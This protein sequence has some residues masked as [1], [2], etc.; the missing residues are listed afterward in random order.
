M[1]M[2]YQSY[3]WYLIYNEYKVDFSIIKQ[4]EVIKEIKELEKSLTK[5]QIENAPKDAENLLGTKLINVD[6]LYKNSL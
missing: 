5:S 3:L 1:D 6:E 2:I 4:E